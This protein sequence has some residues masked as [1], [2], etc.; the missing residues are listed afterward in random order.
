[1]KSHKYC[2]VGYSEHTKNKIIPSILQIGSKIVGIVS[3]KREIDKN[4]HQYK[5]LEDALSNVPKKTIFIL[6]TPPDIHS[7]Q[8]INILKNGFNLFIEKPVT[9]SIS[10]LKK[11]ILL[12]KK[13]NLFFVE[14]FMYKY[15]NIYKKFL[16]IWFQKKREINQ[17][18]IFF[19]IPKIPIK[20]FRTQ[21]TNYSTNLFDI[22]SYLVSVIN[23]LYGKTKF[24]LISVKNFSYPRKEF[25]EIICF[26]KKTKIT[27]KFGVNKY[28]MNKI[29]LFLD[30]NNFYSFKP[31]FYGRSGQRKIEYFVNSKII[32]TIMNEDN[33]FSNMFKKN[34]KYWLSTQE[35]R[36]L[37]MLNNLKS[38]ES[39]NKQYNNIRGNK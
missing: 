12:A 32:R 26:Q 16:K 10:S 28:Y 15:S 6:C 31:F 11:I 38:L 24:K 30:E 5:N 27:G 18:N 25:F 8:A 9:T 39:L 22:G 20:T 17:I 23:D 4:F 19:L 7:T 14:G 29:D 3:K 21:N 1:M 37:S 2:I 33:S 35:E 34:N 13:N 36:N